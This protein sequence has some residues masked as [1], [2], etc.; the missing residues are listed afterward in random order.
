MVPTSAWWLSRIES[1][2][3]VTFCCTFDYEFSLDRQ[4]PNTNL[5][6]HQGDNES[7]ERVGRSVH[8]LCYC[9]PLSTVLESYQRLIGE[10][11]EFYLRRFIDYVFRRFIIVSA[12]L[13]FLAITVDANPWEW[14][15][16]K[17]W[18]RVYLLH[19]PILHIYTFD[20]GLSIVL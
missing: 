9:R 16:K 13:T 20:T 17:R 19:Q 11:E 1:P 5:E 8:Y 18:G 12:S 4:Y 3:Q 7:S 14:R 2:Q 10:A 15:C 6:S